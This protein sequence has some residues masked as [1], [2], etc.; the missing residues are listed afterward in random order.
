MAFLGVV[1]AAFKLRSR[2]LEVD[3][4]ENELRFSFFEI[5]GN[6][7][8]FRRPEPVAGMA[9]RSNG[10]KTTRLPVVVF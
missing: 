4:E 7:T 6:F 8:I 10:Q 2:H 3:F 1:V 9:V 5:L